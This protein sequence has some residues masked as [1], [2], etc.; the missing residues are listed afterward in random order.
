M[1]RI[2]CVVFL[3][4]L[5]LFCSQDVN[6]RRGRGRGRSK[7]KVHGFIKLVFYS[8]KLLFLMVNFCWIR[9]KLVYRSQANIETQNPINTTT[10][11][12]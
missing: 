10:T 4:V 11:T 2:S 6:G 7:S 5:V 8:R 3:V 9:C 1:N 12:M